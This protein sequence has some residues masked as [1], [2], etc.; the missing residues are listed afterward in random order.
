MGQGPH[1][2]FKACEW[3]G[4]V[5]I[6]QPL[7]STDSSPGSL[8]DVHKLKLKTDHSQSPNMVQGKLSKARDFKHGP[9]FRVECLGFRIP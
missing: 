2:T 4:L 5:R 1:A 7:N 3:E 6:P 8:Q 9:G